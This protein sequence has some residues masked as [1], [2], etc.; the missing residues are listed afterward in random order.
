MPDRTKLYEIECDAS[1]FTTGAVLL[2]EDTNG[3]WHPVAFHSKSMSAT[4][5]NYQ[6]YVRELMAVI[7]SL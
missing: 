7:R 6:G 3:D 5:R 4:E 2:Q 1:L